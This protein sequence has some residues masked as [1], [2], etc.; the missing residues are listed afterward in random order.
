MQGLGYTRKVSTTKP[1]SSLCPVDPKKHWLRWVDSLL[2]ETVKMRTFQ[3][4]KKEVVGA[5]YPWRSDHSGSLVPLEP[6]G[7]LHQCQ[8]KPVF[9]PSH[10]YP[11]PM[12]TPA[13]LSRPPSHHNNL[14][15]QGAI[16]TFKV[17]HWFRALE[18]ISECL[19]VTHEESLASFP[20]CCCLL[21]WEWNAEPSTG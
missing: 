6:K 17:S 3:R 18:S 4:G 14:M 9:V 5:W 21:C 11:G 19:V 8:Q 13:I 16:Y 12:W 15:K 10:S 20:A 1:Q 2:P 7:G